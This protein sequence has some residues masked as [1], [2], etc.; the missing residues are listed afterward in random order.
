MI[1]QPC[2]TVAMLRKRLSLVCELWFS[3]VFP[4]YNLWSNLL[5]HAFFFIPVTIEII[6]GDVFIYI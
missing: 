4:S 3:H 2:L 5:T 1:V 6:V